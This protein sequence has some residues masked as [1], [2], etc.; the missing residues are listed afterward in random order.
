MSIRYNWYNA[1]K[2]VIHLVFEQGWTWDEYRRLQA[3]LFAMIDEVNHPVHYL[4]D[5]SAVHAL[6]MGALNYLPAIFSQTHPRR[7]KT[8]IFGAS[9]IIYNL[10]HLLQK[11]F[12]Q[13]DGARYIFVGSMAEAN[14]LLA[15]WQNAG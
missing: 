11:L 7:G 2:A 3:S 6:P 10:W 4:I 1:E 9:P 15:S 8:I 12:Q 13:M 5:I 14:D